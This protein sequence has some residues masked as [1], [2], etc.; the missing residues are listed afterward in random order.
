MSVLENN[1]T[2]GM[3]SMQ[4]NADSQNGLK[5]RQFPVWVKRDMV[6]Q[7]GEHCLFC[8]A[9][10]NVNKKG[11]SESIYNEDDYDAHCHHKKPIY[12]LDE[13]EQ[14]LALDPKNGEVMCKKCH[15]ELH[16]FIDIFAEIEGVDHNFLTTV[17]VNFFC[18]NPHKHLKVK[19][20][21]VVYDGLQVLADRF[22]YLF[23]KICEP[24]TQYLVYAY[25]NHINKLFKSKGKR[26]NKAIQRHIEYEQRDLEQ[27]FE[28]LRFKKNLACIDAWLFNGRDSQKFYARY[29]PIIHRNAKHK[30]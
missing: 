10:F 28:S 18:L 30:R 12:A 17:Y 29:V 21:P 25:Y 14:D 9:K 6:E 5:Q 23:D 2:A 8:S 24:E 11:G 19:Y 16:F 13:E 26:L 3:Q 20:D 1:E 27:A 4:Y 15:E 22:W 7:N